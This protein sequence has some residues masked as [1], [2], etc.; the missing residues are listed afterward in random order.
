MLIWGHGGRHA[1]QN[2]R[3]CG[4]VSQKVGH[5]AR[6]MAAVHSVTWF[7]VTVAGQT[8]ITPPNGKCLSQSLPCSKGGMM[9]NFCMMASR[10]I[11]SIAK[12][13]N[14]HWET[15]ITKVSG[16]HLKKAGETGGMELAFREFHVL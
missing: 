1:F 15:L 6:E 9:G 13:E 4:K 5:T 7:L 11:T 3:N 16:E 12:G 2:V 8:V 14:R 10:P